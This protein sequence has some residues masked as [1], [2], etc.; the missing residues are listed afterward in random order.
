MKFSSKSGLFIWGFLAVNS[1]ISVVNA[2]VKDVLPEN[3]YCSPIID[4]KKYISNDFS[5]VYPRKAHFECTY[6]C[7]ANGKMSTI[8]AVSKVS[9]SSM[10]DDAT[11]V[12]CQG[13]VVKK[14]TWGYDFDKIEPFY[15][16][17]TGLVEIKRWAFENVSQDPK[18]NVEEYALL[19]TLKTDLYQVSA[20]LITAGINGGASAAYFNEAGQK[21]SKIADEL[22]NKTTLLNEAIRQIIVNKGPGKLDGTYLP[23]MNQMLM[24]SA[25]WKI[26]THLF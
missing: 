18:V 21:L 14:V 24:T 23:L 1:L 17:K 9:V 2:S 15:A 12:V 16:Y 7:K 11:S 3:N 13:V 5:L 10:D 19:K 6:R 4:S 8:I 22:P 26:P 25:S 20:A